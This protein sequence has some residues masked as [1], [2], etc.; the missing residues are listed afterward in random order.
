MTIQFLE[1]GYELVMP[2]GWTL[3]LFILTLGAIL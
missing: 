3:H 1:H 2:V